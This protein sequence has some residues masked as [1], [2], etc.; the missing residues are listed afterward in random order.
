M[1]PG[2]VRVSETLEWRPLAL[3]RDTLTRAKVPIRLLP[4]RPVGSAAL[5]RACNPTQL[6]PLDT[7]PMLKLVDRRNGAPARFLAT[8]NVKR[9][10][11]K[12]SQ[13]KLII[14]K[15]KVDNWLCSSTFL[16]LHRASRANHPPARTYC[17]SA[18]P[19]PPIGRHRDASNSQF[20]LAASFK[21][22]QIAPSAPTPGL[23]NPLTSGIASSRERTSAKLGLFLTFCFSRHAPRSTTS[24]GGRGFEPVLMHPGCPA[25]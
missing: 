4:A 12:D 14:L 15:R 9:K 8:P 5:H 7:G 10:R 18:N 21:P 25:F 3:R 13:Y 17:A 23:K 22:S 11:P 6:Q 20:W 19:P 16:F 2:P 1:R 24:R